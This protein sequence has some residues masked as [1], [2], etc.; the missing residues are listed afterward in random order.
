VK[1][2]GFSAVDATGSPT[3][4]GAHQSAPAPVDLSAI[5]DEKLMQ[6]LDSMVQ[7]LAD[8]L[9]EAVLTEVNATGSSEVGSAAADSMPNRTPT[10]PTPH[11]AEPPVEASSADDLLNSVMAEAEDALWQDL[12]RLI[13]VSTEDV[14][15]A[16]LSGDISAFESIDFEALQTAQTPP[17]PEFLTGSPQPSRSPQTEPI[18]PTI[19]P[20]ASTDATF[21]AALDEPIAND[22]ESAHSTDPV[23]SP[24]VFG[25][26]PGWPAP[27]IYPTR[28]AKKRR[29]LAA[30]DLPSFLQPGPLPT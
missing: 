13:D 20:P 30:V 5:P 8:L 12:A 7:P 27:L 22:P 28:P 29:S 14:V 3:H 4:A 2:P 16:S 17:A 6:K 26:T 10:A 15:K 21:F 9:A 25:A 24:S 23:H 19:V 18:A 1:L 11:L